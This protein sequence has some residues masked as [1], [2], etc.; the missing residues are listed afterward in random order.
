LSKRGFSLLELLIAI[1]LVGAVLFPLLQELGS[2]VAASAS[3]E[4]EVISLNL[5]QEKMES[6]LALPYNSLT[7]EARAP[8]SG[9]PSFQREVLLSIPQPNLKKAKVIVYWTPAQG[10]ERSISF[11]S[12]VA[13]Y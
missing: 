6:L 9:Y 7:W 3:S 1:F 5:A 8:I 12:C 13:N 10:T 4:S 11:E 2:V